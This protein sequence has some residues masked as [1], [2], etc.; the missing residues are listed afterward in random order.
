MVELSEGVF[1]FAGQNLQGLGRGT[2][3][4]SRLSVRQRTDRL[5]YF[6]PKR[7][8][9]QW[10][11]GGPLLELVHIAQIKG[12]RLG[13]E[14]FV[15]PL[16]PPLADEGIIPWQSTFLVFDVLRVKKRPNLSPMHTLDMFVEAKSIT[17]SDTSVELVNVIFEE[18]LPVCKK[19]QKKNCRRRRFLPTQL[20]IAKKRPSQVL[21]PLLLPFATA[22]LLPIATA[23]LFLDDRGRV[24]IG[25]RM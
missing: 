23:V 2:I 20:V 14:Q 21:T 13:V 6:V 22:V 25:K 1:S 10:S 16:H 4:P 24:G 19:P 9:V 17:F 7:D 8:I 5:L 12:R 18:P 15:K 3:G 11:A